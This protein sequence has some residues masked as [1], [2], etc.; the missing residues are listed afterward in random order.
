[1][2]ILNYEIVSCLDTG[3]G[4]AELLE[5]KNAELLDK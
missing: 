2:I 5:N 1:M 3:T 4:F